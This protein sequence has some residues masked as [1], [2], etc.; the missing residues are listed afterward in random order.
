MGEKFHRELAR[1]EASVYEMGGLANSMLGESMH[2]LSGLDVSVAE[3]VIAR[4]K[5]IEEMDESIEDEALKLIALYQPV[6]RDMRTIA[7]SLKMI[8]YITR[9]GKYAKDISVHVRELELKKEVKRNNAKK[10]FKMAKLV[11]GMVEDALSAYRNRDVSEL[12]GFKE[13][14]DEVDK[15]FAGFFTECEKTSEKEC[16]A[17]TLCIDHLMIARYLERC[18]DHACKMAEKVYYMVTG[19]R[20][21]VS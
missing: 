3:K 15:L 2:A 20:M 5:R 13:R 12:S 16:G 11:S 17:V 18:G 14:D 7:S 8:T 21:K 4:E 19:E 6:A 10:L 1:L 9:I